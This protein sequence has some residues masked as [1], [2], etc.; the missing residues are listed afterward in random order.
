MDDDFEAA[1]R[2]L[3]TLDRIPLPTFRAP[4]WEAIR[5]ALPQ[6][7]ELPDGPVHVLIDLDIDEHGV[8]VRAEVGEAPED[9]GNV[10]AVCVDAQGT[11]IPS[12]TRVDLQDGVIPSAARDLR[13]RD[14]ASAPTIARAI[15]RAIASAH[16]GARFTPGIRGGQPVAVRRFRMGIEVGPEELRAT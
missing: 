8:V 4:P 10:I 12:A 1:L 14:R 11:V 5:A 15:A 7:T 3:L 16:L 6:G 13:D 2:E 9:V